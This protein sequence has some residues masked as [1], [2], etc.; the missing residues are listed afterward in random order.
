[1]IAHLLLSKSVSSLSTFL[2]DVGYSNYKKEEIFTDYGKKSC[3]EEEKKK[4]RRRN[5]AVYTA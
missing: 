5:K 3:E 4:K 2:T 1:M